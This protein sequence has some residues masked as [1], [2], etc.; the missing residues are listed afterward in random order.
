MKASDLNLL[1]VEVKIKVQKYKIFVKIKVN[2][3]KYNDEII[4]KYAQNKEIT[5]IAI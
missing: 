4:S 3:I 1:S 2:K 5:A